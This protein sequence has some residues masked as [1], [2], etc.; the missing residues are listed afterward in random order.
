[1]AENET[2]FD[3]V[4]N[5]KARSDVWQHFWLKFDIAAKKAVDG[6][7]ICRLCDQAVMYSS[8][9]TNLN[10]H[11]NRTVYRRKGSYRFRTAFPEPNPL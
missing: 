5:K 7:A 9:T 2:G 8:G 10:T 11:L 4:P 3:F 1:M 6:K